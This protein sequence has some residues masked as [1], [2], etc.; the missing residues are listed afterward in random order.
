MAGLTSFQPRRNRRAVNPP[1]R[2]LPAFTGLRAY[3]IALIRPRLTDHYD[4][5][6][7]QEEADFA[8]PFLDEYINLC[9]D[10]FLL[11]KSPAQQE[12]GLYMSLSSSFNHLGYLTRHGKERE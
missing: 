1:R 3:P 7:T 6:V 5:S 4:L 10:P 12:Q 11:W 8:I 2:P 9:V